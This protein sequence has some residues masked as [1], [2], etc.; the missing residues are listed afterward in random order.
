MDRQAIYV[1][2]VSNRMILIKILVKAI[3]VSVISVYTPECCL[4]DIQKD[5]LYDPL[6]S[7]ATKMRKRKLLPYQ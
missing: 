3:F 7:D 6:I 5:H 1:S 4:D 2:R